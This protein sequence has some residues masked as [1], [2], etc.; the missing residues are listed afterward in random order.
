MDRKLVFSFVGPIPWKHKNPTSNRVISI[1]V[2]AKFT[3][4]IT[5]L[6]NQTQMLQAWANFHLLILW[7]TLA[8]VCSE[9]ILHI[10]VNGQCS[11]GGHH[12]SNGRLIITVWQQEHDTAY[13]TTQSGEGTQ[14]RFTFWRHTYPASNLAGIFT[15]IS[16]S[17]GCM[18]IFTADIVSPYCSC[19]LT[20]T[21]ETS[22]RYHKLFSLIHHYSPNI[23]QP[24]IHRN[25]LCVLNYG[26]SSSTLS[27]RCTAGIFTAIHIV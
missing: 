2:L 21:H 19:Q 3:G 24:C 26:G 25:I 12:T 20:V 4:Q 15:H 7:P 11:L 1:Y 13:I 9:L 22:G 6:I 27:L 14:D 8:S 23:F 17:L 10:G 5:A 18:T 16:L